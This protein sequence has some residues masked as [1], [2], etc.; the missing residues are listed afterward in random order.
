MLACAEVSAVEC[1]DAFAAHVEYVDACKCGLG[2]GEGDVRAVHVEPGLCCKCD[3][4][5]CCCC[6]RAVLVVELDTCDVS[7]ALVGGRKEFCLLV[8]SV[9]DDSV[10]RDHVVEEHRAFKTVCACQ[11]E[12]DREEVVEVHRVFNACVIG[13]GLN[14]EFAGGFGAVIE[15]ATVGRRLFP[16]PCVIFGAVADKC[17][18]D[19]DAV[20][21]AAGTLVFDGDC[22]ALCASQFRNLGVLDVG[23]AVVDGL[24]GHAHDEVN[25]FR[26]G[27]GC[28]CTELGVL[29]RCRADVRG[30]CSFVIV[31][32]TRHFV[33]GDDAFVSE[34]LCPHVG[35]GLAY[36]ASVP[37]RRFV[38]RHPPAP[39]GSVFVHLFDVRNRAVFA[40]G[41]NLVGAGLVREVDER[42]TVALVVIG[43]VVNVNAQHVIVGFAR[44]PGHRGG[45][46]RV[47]VPN[48]VVDAVRE[49]HAF[50]EQLVECGE[51]FAGMRAPPEPV[52]T[53]FMEWAEDGGNAFFLEVEEN[54][55]DEIDV[56]DECLVSGRD[57][58]PVGRAGYEC[59]GEVEFGVI[60][61]C[62]FDIEVFFVTWTPVPCECRNAAL[63][64]C[65]LGDIDGLFGIFLEPTIVL[66]AA[67]CVHQVDSNKCGV[68]AAGLE[69]GL[70][71]FVLGGVTFGIGVH[72]AG[73][74]AGDGLFAEI[75]DEEVVELFRGG[76]RVLGHGGVAEVE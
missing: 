32:P 14:G 26:I 17:H 10:V 15:P 27:L 21:F 44:S 22:D 51:L 52:T 9:D 36:I 62:A 33:E 13:V 60:V 72:V 37:A 1:R 28:V 30:C 19:P 42:G 68:L 24:V 75:V 2:G 29:R 49:D 46:L 74:D 39:C 16:S 23:A 4:L 53:G 69:Y 12:G 48:E 58:V 43:L 76:G 18:A 65:A 20:H 8:E 57:G 55:G 54:F 71:V 45:V 64:P 5:D 47:K 50:V 56:T 38:P 63:L 6:R 34:V 3:W 7:L 11:D 35:C 61:I 70:D 59:F 73:H 41:D 40:E 25:V 66:A 31:I 67:G